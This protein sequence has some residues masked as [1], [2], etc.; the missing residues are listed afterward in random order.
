MH[1]GKS[2]L[3]RM[4]TSGTTIGYGE[5]GGKGILLAEFSPVVLLVFGQHEH[6]LH[7]VV[8][9]KKA[10]DGVHQDRFAMDRKELLGNVASHAQSLSTGYDDDG[11]HARPA[12]MA[13]G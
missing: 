2:V 6:D 3:H 11:I 10:L 9:L 12:L 8:E 5:D 7:G 13:S 4:K 1:F